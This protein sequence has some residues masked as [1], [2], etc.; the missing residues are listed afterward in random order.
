MYQWWICTYVLGHSPVNIY[1]P[2]NRKYFQFSSH[3]YFTFTLPEAIEEKC[4]NWMKKIEN[5][6]DSLVNVYLQVS[7]QARMYRSD[8]VI[9]NIFVFHYFLCEGKHSIFLLFILEK[10]FLAE[11]SY[12]LLRHKLKK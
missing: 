10:W 2:M 4:R 1:S 3:R 6:S 8:T 9:L 5:I 11:Y 7:D 12:K